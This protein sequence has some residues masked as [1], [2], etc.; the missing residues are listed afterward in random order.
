MGRRLTPFVLSLADRLTVEALTSKGR[1][2]GR[3]VQR[4]RVLL[5]LA[6]GVSG[7]TVAAELG[8][9]MQT[10]YQVRRR[11]ALTESGPRRAYGPGLHAG[12]HQAQ[13]LDTVPGGNH[14]PRNRGAGARKNELRPRRQQHGCPDAGNAAFLARMEDVLAVYER[15]YDPLFLVVCFSERPCVLHGQLV[16]LPP[17]VPAQPARGE[18]IASAGRPRWESSTYVC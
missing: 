11:G 7:H 6:G 10:V 9:R 15:A 18:Q 16:A 8:C 4:G 17:P 2:A 13:Q 1:H 3:T 12:P 14:F 5:R